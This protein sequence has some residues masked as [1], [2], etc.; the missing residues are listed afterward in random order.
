[1][2][3]VAPL[4]LMVEEAM[5]V[6][7]C[8]AQAAISVYASGLGAIPALFQGCAQQPPAGGCSATQGDALPGAGSLFTLTVERALEGGRH[9]RSALRIL[10]SPGVTRPCPRLAPG[11]GHLLP[12]TG[13]LPWVVE[14]LLE[15]NSLTFLLLCVTLPGTPWD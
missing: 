7:V 2:M 8:D 13:G 4:G 14:Q 10:A 6:A 1:M 15:G 11:T 12:D 3:D 9:Q 5:E